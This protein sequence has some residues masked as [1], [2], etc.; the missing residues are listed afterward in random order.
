MP[1]MHFSVAQNKTVPIEILANLA[2]FSD[3]ATRNMVAR[4]RKITEPIGMILSEDVDETVRAALA[5]NVRL[6]KS[7]RNVLR[8]DRSPLVQEAIAIHQTKG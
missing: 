7:V 4:K 5:R 1:E 8:R 6:P 2:Q 3:A